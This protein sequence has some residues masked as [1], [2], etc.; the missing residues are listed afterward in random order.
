MRA[1]LMGGLFLATAVY[2][3]AAAA[4]DVS[5]A[6]LDAIAATPAEKA[7]QGRLSYQLDQV[8]DA[9]EHGR[10]LYA[11]GGHPRWVD[12]GTGRITTIVELK[13]GSRPEDLTGAVAAA[14]G[15]IEGSVFDHVK[16]VVPPGGLRAVA[17]DPAVRVMRQPYYAEPKVV[18]QGVKVIK[19]DQ[20][21]GRTGD[22]GKGVTV[23]VS[24]ADS[25][26]QTSQLVGN[27]LPS[28]TVTTPFVQAGNFSSSHGT[29]C[30][31][32]VHDVAPG[33]KLV[34]DGS[35]SD[36]VAWGRA[37]QA[38]A[39]RDGVKIIS[40]S[41]GFDNVALPNG[42]NYYARVADS[43][44]AAGVLFVTAAGNEG[45]RY[46]ISTWSDKD[47]DGV[48]EF[49]GRTE[50]LPIR[51]GSGAF[52]RLRWDDPFGASN[53]DYDLFVFDEGGYIMGRSENGQRGI[54][55]PVEEVEL[56]N[57]FTGIGSVE[58]RHDPRTPIKGNQKLYVYIGGPGWLDPG[59][60]TKTGTLSLPADARDAVAVGAV[61]FDSRELQ[62]SSARGPTADDRVKPDLTGPS[63]VSTASWSG[64][65]S[66]TSAATPHVAGAAALILSHNPG[67]DVATL[68]RE[69]LKATAS[70]GT[71][72]NN[73]VGYGLLD[74]SAAK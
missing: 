60:S 66:G 43:V 16:V 58:V 6:A 13:P 47:G 53:H 30:A 73:D 4:E 10:A 65:F 71:N 59:Y 19:A 32:I 49:Y 15:T 62:P 29:A 46:N 38:L 24:D 28:D 69:L 1:V 67:M 34:L 5:G 11:R 23:G 27:E 17:A 22:D 70:G 72:R 61:D 68:R 9:H 31:E 50:S 20:Y 57:G 42:A 35:A 54:E 12:A 7:R 36:E 21:V 37:L 45:L 52:V 56:P 3:A 74:M 8:A 18:S 25:F 40:H 44:N 63:G 26:A 41:M 14:G 55:D 48:L 33:A 51:A 39:Q 2:P 64:P